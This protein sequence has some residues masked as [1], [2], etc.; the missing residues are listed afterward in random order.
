MAAVRFRSCC[1]PHLASSNAGERK[2]RR[3]S[4]NLGAKCDAKKTLLLLFLGRLLDGLLDGFLDLLLSSHALTSFAFDTTLNACPDSSRADIRHVL[5]PS[6][7]LAA[8]FPCLGCKSP[9]AFPQLLQPRPMLLDRVPSSGRDCNARIRFLV[10]EP[11]LDRHQSGVA[12]F[13]KM[14]REIPIR[15]PR[16]S[17]QEHEVSAG[18]GGERRQDDQPGRLVYE[19]VQRVDVFKARGQ[20]DSQTRAATWSGSCGR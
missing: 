8:R 16:Q 14:S 12:Q 20:P 15:Q 17:L 19:P 9:R 10:D 5:S 2:S 3:G 7:G 11:F 4:G 1:G 18:A 6:A 13:R